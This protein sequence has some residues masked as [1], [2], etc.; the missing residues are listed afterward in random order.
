M[1]TALSH[2]SVISSEQPNPAVRTPRAARRRLLQVLPSCAHEPF[3]W[4]HV[5]PMPFVVSG[6]L[7]G[8]SRT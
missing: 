6:A 1:E 5:M 3:L 8:P 7:R 4:R 2:R